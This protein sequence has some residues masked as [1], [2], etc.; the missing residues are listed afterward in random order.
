MI[1]QIE[2][3]ENNIVP[4]GY[5]SVTYKSKSFSPVT[6]FQDFPNRGIVIYLTI[7]RRRWRKKERKK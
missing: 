7:K 5:D 3:D 2:L 4:E 6:I 1:L